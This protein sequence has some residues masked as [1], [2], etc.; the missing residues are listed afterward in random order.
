MN[1]SS[2][3]SYFFHVEKIWT[4]RYGKL[5][6]NLDVDKKWKMEIGK[7]KSC[8]PR[9][10]ADEARFCQEKENILIELGW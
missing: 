5:L 8:N 9:R 10:L 7:R 4:D 3:A 2:T 1:P 6:M